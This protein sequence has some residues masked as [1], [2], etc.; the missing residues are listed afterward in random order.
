M[1]PFPFRLA[2]VD[3]DDTLLGHDKEISRANYHAIHRLVQAGVLVVL[4][5]GRRHENM[6]RFY[7]ELDLSSGWIVSCNGAMAKNETTGETIHEQLLPQQM[8]GAILSD[9]I[10]FGVT[11]NFYHRDGGLFVNASNEWTDIYKARTK[12]ELDVVGDILS[13]SDEPALKI[14]WVTSAENAIE[15]G[16]AM[17]AKHGEEA[18]HIVITD[19]EYLEFMAQGVNKAAG[20]A[21]V[22]ERLGIAPSECIAFGDGNNDVE[23][24]QWAGYGVAMPHARLAAQQAANMVAPDGD[25]ETAFARAVEMLFAERG[26]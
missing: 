13:L 25:P 23:M 11:Q 22:A 8:V 14:I 9:G 1:M 19:P 21:H 2:A 17:R 7:N 10:G 6:R 15:L 20:L 4:A 5:S 3:L 16:A 24:L 18:L 26:L 12:S